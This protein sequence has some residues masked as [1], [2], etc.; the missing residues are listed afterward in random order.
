MLVLF[1]RWEPEWTAASVVAQR[2]ARPL[3]AVIIRLAVMRPG[4][5]QNVVLAVAFLA[6][7]LSSQTDTALDDLAKSFN[8]GEV[9]S[10]EAGIKL[11]LRTRWEDGVCASHGQFE[12]VAGD[13]H[14]NLADVYT[15]VYYLN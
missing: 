10:T 3:C 9:A 6:S 5:I 12:R 14:T 15:F 4:V 2:R 7:P 11:S 1:H 13:A 8:W